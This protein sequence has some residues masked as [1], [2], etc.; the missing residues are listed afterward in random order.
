MISILTQGLCI[1]LMLAMKRF[2]RY[3]INYNTGLVYWT[4][5]D[6]KIRRYDVNYNTACVLD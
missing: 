3:G 4:D 6:K 1:G 2:M 5:V